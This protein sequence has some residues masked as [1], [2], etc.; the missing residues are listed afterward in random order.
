LRAEGVPSY[1]NAPDRWAV[2]SLRIREETDHP[3]TGSYAYG[4]ASGRYGYGSAN[5]SFYDA[6]TGVSGST[7]QH[8]TPYSRWGSSTVS[9]P[10]QT[11]NTQSAGNAY[12][13]A[14]RFKSSNGAEGA[15]YYNRA[16]GSSG[17]AGRTPNG[18]VYAGRDGNVYQHSENGWSKW[19][20][21]S[22]TSMTPSGGSPANKAVEPEAGNHAVESR[23]QIDQGSFQ[24]LQ[25]DR[26]G[27]AAGSGQFA[28][29]LPG[30]GFGGP[31]AGGGP[32]GR[33][34]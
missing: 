4:S 12:G 21:G 29:R 22:W 6:R 18:D 5:G 8:W 2:R 19:S 30:G 17:G 1:T 7:D 11:V 32:P 31:F 28:G 23:N 10:N 13:D 14:G 9:G 27:R 25:H 33:P 26:L 20:N 15:G 24:Q 3:S 16:T 34:R